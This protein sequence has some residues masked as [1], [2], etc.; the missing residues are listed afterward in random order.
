[1]L[2]DIFKLIVLCLTIAAWITGV[3]FIIKSILVRKIEN[4]TTGLLLIIAGSSFMFSLGLM[5]KWIEA[6][7]FS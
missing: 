2:Y 3:G 6:G 7:V 5:I 1:M 4:F